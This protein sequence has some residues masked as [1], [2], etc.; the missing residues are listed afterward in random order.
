MNKT[1]MSETEYYSKKKSNHTD[2][3]L[4][5]TCPWLN[6]MAITTPSTTESKSA[7]S[8]TTT[9]D[10]PPNSNEIFLPV[11]AVTRLKILPT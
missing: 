4:M 8:K 1:R 2:F 6:Q 5:H 10:F 3:N 9:G 7:E 11:P